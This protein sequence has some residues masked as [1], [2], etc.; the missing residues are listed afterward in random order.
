MIDPTK[1]P[2]VALVDTGVLIRALGQRS[3]DPR[4][5]VCVAFWEEM[6]RKGNTILIAAPTVTEVTRS[7]DYPPLPVPSVPNVIVVAFDREAAVMLAKKFPE[8]VIRNLAGKI[9]IDYIRY[10]ALIAACAIR[11]KA[12]LVTLD[13]SLT[14]LSEKGDIPHAS[15]SDYKRRQLSLEERLLPDKT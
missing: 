8:Q 11:Y 5:P 12:T 9:P 3:D 10:D 13:G 1:L 14:K 7:L 15:V 2:D 6:L 4:A